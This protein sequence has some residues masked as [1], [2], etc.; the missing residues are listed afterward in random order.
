MIIPKE[1]LKN[2]GMAILIIILFF[3][4]PYFSSSIIHL[5]PFSETSQ[6]YLRF[7]SSFVFMFLLIALYY[8]DL[9]KDLLKYKKNMK[10]YLKTGFL[11]LL[12]GIVGMV[13][14]NFIIYVVLFP[15]LEMMSDLALVEGFQT[16]A[17]LYFL[18]TFLYY[19]ITEELVF[20]K[21]LKNIFISK[22]T[23][24][25]VTAFIN[26]F[27]T[28]AFSAQNFLSYVGILPLLVLNASF[29]YAYYKTDNLLV[30]IS[31]RIL[32]NLIPTIIF[33]LG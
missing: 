12:I 1:R 20:K 23:F 9:R 18:M 26:V 19:P 13:L 17:F 16:N 22:W 14:L 27:F 5:F 31:M 28:I 29:S 10:S 25:L 32:Y 11:S 15:N 24:T 3:V 8:D 4:W 6:L 21:S 33:F 7:F 2:L 30:G